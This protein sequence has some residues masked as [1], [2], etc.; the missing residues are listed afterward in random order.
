MASFKELY[1]DS[2]SANEISDHKHYEER[3][4]EEKQTR[5][6]QELYEFLPSAALPTDEE[7]I[8]SLPIH[9]NFKGN[10]FRHLVEEVSKYPDLPIEQLKLVIVAPNGQ[11]EL[12]GGSDQSSVARKRQCQS[13]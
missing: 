2:I 1:F 13:E 4:C 3:E 8:R 11:Q 12:F 10:L 7:T 6:S 5:I 9:P